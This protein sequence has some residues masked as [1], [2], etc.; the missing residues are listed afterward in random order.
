MG[1]NCALLVVDLLLC[2]VESLSLFYL[3]LYLDLYLIGDDTS[4]S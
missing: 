1:T 4:L 3:V 2:P